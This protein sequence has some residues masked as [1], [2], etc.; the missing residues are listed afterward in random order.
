[1]AKDRAT[2]PHKEG[3]KKREKKVSRDGVD[4]HKKDKKDK[5]KSKRAVTPPSADDDSDNSGGAP[6]VEP[7]V[8]ETKQKKKAGK[9]SKK[10]AEADATSLFAIDTNPTPVDPSAVE[11]AA[12]SGSEDEG[13]EA[14]LKKQKQKGSKNVP[15]PSGLNRAARRRIKLIERQRE[16]IQKRLGIP[17]GSQERADE[18]QRELDQWTERYDEKAAIRAKKRKTRQEKEAARVKNKRGKVLTG[19]KLKERNKGLA[20]I[21]KKAAKKQGKK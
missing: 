4:K 20:T 16:V 6:V 9:D 11:A 12:D 3:E 18:V 17:E 10:K 1:M 13:V 5:K 8:K 19:R 7:E 15:A 2:K 21:E 14:K